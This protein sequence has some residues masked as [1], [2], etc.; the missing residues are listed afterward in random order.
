MLKDQD[1]LGVSST[2]VQPP[3]RGQTSTTMVKEEDIDYLQKGYRLS[4]ADPI[5]LGPKDE[6]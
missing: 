6:D 5:L 3:F 4:M 1:K 2:S